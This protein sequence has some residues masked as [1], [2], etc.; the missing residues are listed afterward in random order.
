MGLPAA[1]GQTAIANRKVNFL[2]LQ[3]PLPL[4]HCSQPPETLPK[5]NCS[6]VFTETRSLSLSSAKGVTVLPDDSPLFSLSY[7]QWQNKLRF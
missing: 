2:H 7:G 5:L 6:Q 4:A 1:G 3:T